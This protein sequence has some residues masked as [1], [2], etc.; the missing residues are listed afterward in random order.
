VA[1][2]DSR[3]GIA[4]ARTAGLRTVGVTT[5]YHRDDLGD[6][7]LIIASIDELD[8]AALDRLCPD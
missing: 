2:E 3:W 8:M 5:T 1:I 7:D 4:S 6:A